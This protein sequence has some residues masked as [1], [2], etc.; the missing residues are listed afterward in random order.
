MDEDAAEA[1]ARLVR[2]LRLEGEG[3]VGGVAY[4]R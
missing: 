3:V 4:D 2:L 1:L